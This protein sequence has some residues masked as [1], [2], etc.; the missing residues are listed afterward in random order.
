MDFVEKYGYI[1]LKSKIRV[2]MDKKGI[3]NDPL[4]LDILTVLT[5]LNSAFSWFYI[6]WKNKLIFWDKIILKLL[7]LL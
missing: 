1:L 7:N 2:N 3:L 5:Y 6:L 4:I